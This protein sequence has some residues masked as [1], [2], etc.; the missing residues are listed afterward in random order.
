MRTFASS[1]AAAFVLLA[2]GASGQHSFSYGGTTSIT[3]SFTHCPETIC[4][5]APVFRT[6][7]VAELDC[8]TN[9][10]LEQD[11][12][13]VESYREGL[14][15]RTGLKFAVTTFVHTLDSAVK[16]EQEWD[17][18]EDTSVHCEESIFVERQ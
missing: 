14:S 3:S 17:L 9:Q 6:V 7:T 10:R 4:V 16:L 5:S 12:W 1:I 8:S 15:H 13:T 2:T 18:V 11:G